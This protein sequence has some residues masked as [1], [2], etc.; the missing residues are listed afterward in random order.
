MQNPNE[1]TE[2]NDVLRAHGIL[3]PRPP[4]P[5]AEL[6]AAMEEAV[7]R[8]HANRLEGKDLDELDELEDDGL[9][10]EEFI[11]F[12]REKRMAEIKAQATRER[13]GSVIHISK[14][15]YTEEITDASKQWPVFVHIS[16]GSTDQSRLLAALLLRMA[17]RFKD[18][19]FVDIDCRQINDHYPSSK[20]PTILIYKDGTL[21]DQIVTLDTI[22]GT[23]TN[24]HDLDRLLVKEQIVSPSDPRLLENQDE[25][26]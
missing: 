10:D 24:L 7:E 9:E 11:Q 22:G 13:F 3:P 15:Q 25:S 6:E 4:S 12:Y 26:D 8:A 23:S 2:W 20:C 1:D 19:K 18:V 17:P 21:K 14:P 16:G 5:T